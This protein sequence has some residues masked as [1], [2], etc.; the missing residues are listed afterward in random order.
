MEQQQQQDRDGETATSFAQSGNQR[1]CYCCGQEG[2]LSPDCPDRNK[3]KNQWFINRALQNMQ[4]E[5]NNNENNND[6]DDRSTASISS[7]RS[8]TNNNNNNNNNNT[9]Y[10]YIYFVFCASAKGTFNLLIFHSCK[11]NKKVV[12]ATKK[13][14]P[15]LVRALFML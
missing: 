10:H 14:N 8:E 11:G 3:P 2:H 7:R 4:S 13:R 15:H 1:V 12:Y 9:C 6:D 5:S